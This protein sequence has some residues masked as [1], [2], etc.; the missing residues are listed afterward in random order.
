MA[1]GTRRIA[2]IA[3][4]FVTA[5]VL[6]LVLGAGYGP[7]PPLARVLDPGSG[8]WASSDNTGVRDQTLTLAG[9]SRP[10]TVSF[11]RSGYAS[12][13]AASETDLYLAQGYVSASQRFTQMD[14]ERRAGEGLL[15]QL[16]GPS[17][18]ASDEFELELGLARTARAEWAAMAPGS[19]AARA[20]TAYARGV[21]DYLRQ[22]A[23]GG[24]W[25]PIYA[26]TGV[27]PAPWTPVDSLV[28]Q[29]L[30]T[31][32]LDFS[33]APLDYQL[34][35]QSLGP[36]L[37][38]SWFPVLPVTSSAQQP[39][40]PG[41]YA[42]PAPAP[43]AT[44]NAAAVAPA[45]ASAD[46]AT[47]SPPSS[48][49]ARAVSAAA[50]LRGIRGLPVAEHNVNLDSNAW[51]VNGPLADGRALLA[52]DPHLQLTLPSTWFEVS[53]A[54]P[55][56]DVA[57]GSIPG[58]P[59]V[60]IGYNSHVSWSITNTENQSTFF[61][62]EKTD[63]AHPDAYY[64]DG[65]W[66]PMAELHYSIPVRGASPVHLTVHMTVHGPVMTMDGQTV[67]VTWMG[68]YPSDDIAAVL[69]IDQATDFSG[70]RSALRGWHAPTVTFVYAD[71]RGNIGAVSPGYFPQTASG[72]QPWL[73]MPGS[74]ADDVIGTIPYQA[75][76]QVY[77][78]PS[79]VV[80][81]TNQRPV[82]DDYPY[83]I[84][85]SLNFDPGYRE[86][87]ILD[88]VENQ[89]PLTAEASAALQHN[90]TDALA[91]SLVPALLD[92]LSHT[93]LTA[94]QRAALDELS[95]WNDAMTT[96]SA[97]ASVWS[98]F[99]QD[100]MSSV[101]QPWWNVDK[102]PVGQDP[103]TL[104]LST[105]PIPLREALEQWTLHDPG[106]SAFTPPGG[107]R[108]DAADVMRTAFVNAVADLAK[109]LGND[110]ATWTWGR[111]HRVEVPSLTGV[112]GLGYGPVPAGGDLWTVDAADGGLVYS[113][114]PSWRM[115]VGWNGDG[116]ATA[117][118][119]YPG[120]QSDDPT[121]PWY[122][123]LLPLWFDGRP[124]PLP[125]SSGPG[126]GSITWNLRAGA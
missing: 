124:L 98:T 13:T 26:L 25:P 36:K 22:L 38:M 81:V 45:N 53:L 10:V 117:S 6:M 61:Y 74:G 104:D 59:G 70:F 18:E 77:D 106:N 27:R 82:S 99:L 109:Q 110:P 80:A 57:G 32:E 21:N 95:S 96:G 113:F 20:L 9:L 111:L 17:Q 105:S 34:L 63:A 24:R 48:A 88:S 41:P 76:P 35:E 65:A 40:D 46:V 108:R 4:A 49:R 39:Y 101:F 123:N 47:I 33:T 90:V 2:N 54:A 92:A 66:R 30:L 3:G 112:H 56:C 73:P 115:I 8:V 107:A 5:G 69:G 89:R 60:L 64:W 118:A 58:T 44:P 75:V 114:G 116:R 62:D 11:T 51:A 31:Q 119:I 67:S 52:G 37:T 55:G 29:E 78:P 68:D 94:T 1:V 14:L 12:I 42:D 83:Y 125:A 15:S 121:S 50:I 120:G 122:E 72:S 86:S 93:P 28:V 7:V 16:D 103:S 126:S 43:F 71:D 97:A 102:V 79:H 85:T 19:P 100:Y 23:A 84:G 87:V 91:E